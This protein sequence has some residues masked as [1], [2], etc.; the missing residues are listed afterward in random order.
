M[1]V[2]NPDGLEQIEAFPWAYA[3]WI[4]NPIAPMPRGSNYLGAIV[5]PPTEDPK[6]Y[7][8]HY[9]LPYMRKGTNATITNYQDLPEIA[10]TLSQQNGGAKMHAGRTRIEY[11]VNGQMVEE[12]IYVSLYL[13][14]FNLGVNNSTSILWGPALPPYGLRAAKGQLDAATP[15]LLSCVNSCQ[16]NPYWF[17]EY[18]YVCDL[19]KNRLANATRNA[20]EISDHITRN[21][22]EIRQMF[23]ESY[24]LRQ[25][26]L[27]K[28][29][30]NF[31]DYIRGVERYQSPHA[32]Y[33]VE[34]P[35]GYKS[36]WVSPSGTYIL[37]ND[38]N[39][40]PNSDRN[41]TGNWTQMQQAK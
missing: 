32:T 31:S 35:A 4:V 33:P 25:K 15:L 22:E 16:I 17:G 14:S 2:T 8:R 19:F 30:Q 1:R 38:A 37:S 41:R 34:L 10:K 36:Y 39:Y 11:K 23:R 24:E 20:R 26:T 6:E 7:V 12:D 3:T 18:S 5:E 27:D 28:V 29:N 9:V 21:N 13:T 40:N